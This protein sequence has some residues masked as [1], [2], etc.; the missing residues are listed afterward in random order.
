VFVDL[1]IQHSTRMCHIVVCGLSGSVM[2]LYLPSHTELFSE[3]R[4]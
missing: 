2:F 4:Y 3:K 1:G